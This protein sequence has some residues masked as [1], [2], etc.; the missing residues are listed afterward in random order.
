M[1]GVITTMRGN[2]SVIRLKNIAL[3]IVFSASTSA[4]ALAQTPQ[5]ATSNLETLLRPGMTVWITDTSG[6][7]EKTRI[8][9]VSGAVITATADGDIRRFDT[10]DVTRVRVR[11]SDSLLNGALIGAGTAVATG[12]FMCSLMEPWEN[13]RDDVGPMLQIGAIG[14]GIG[15]G[16]DAL[17]R[18][19]RTIYEGGKTSS[20]QAGFIVGPQTKGVRVSIRF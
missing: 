8:Q 2:R 1:L 5:G 9:G 16:V 3:L 7:E 11:E 14:A 13:C 19:R 4:A 10:A 15:I 18:G 17:I 6:R 20:L 12:L